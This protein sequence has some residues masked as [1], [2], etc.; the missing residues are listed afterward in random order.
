MSG[1]GVHMGET[2]RYGDHGG[3]L[4]ATKHETE[5]PADSVLFSIDQGTCWH[6]IGLE[7]AIDVGN[8]R[9]APAAL[10]A[11]KPGSGTRAGSRSSSRNVC[12]C[13][14]RYTGV[15]TERVL[16][17]W[18]LRP[19]AT[20]LWCMAR[21]ARSGQRIRRAPTRALAPTLLAGCTS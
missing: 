10:N 5:G 16:A 11:F 21:R 7:E 2:G 4:I 18:S 3:L 15:L 13:Y 17:E 12:S 19:L 9:R 6:E 8:I 1:E 14:H 20:C